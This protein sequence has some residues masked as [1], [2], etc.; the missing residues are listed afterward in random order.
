MT[1]IYYLQALGAT[2]CLLASLLLTGCGKPK[3]A[4][5]SPAE[6]LGLNA[7]TA[8]AGPVVAGSRPSAAVTAT[9]YV[10]PPT[11]TS[12]AM[13]FEGEMV[14]A[15]RRPED[16][17]AGRVRYVWKGNK[18]RVQLFGLGTDVD[19][20]VGDE[21]VI[22]L[23][24][25]TKS[26]RIH[27]VDNLAQAADDDRERLSFT[28]SGELHTRS[29]I[30]CEQRRLVTETLLVD[31]CVHGVPG[32]FTVGLFEKA[33]GLRLPE[34]LFGLVSDSTFPVT[35]SVRDSKG[36]E[37][38]SVIV[39]HYASEPVDDAAFFVPGSYTQQIN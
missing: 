26:Y 16:P 24:G 39:T 32:D 23:N 34:W 31:A 35:A 13:S 33:S 9:A 28:V 25:A 1:T 27:D 36:T 37:R 8:V 22:T 30:L 18:L 17:Q 2:G 12:L 29:G 38:L 21:R 10:T 15:V 4:D 20:I 3:S 6:A 11:F 14:G 7:R 5:A 19:V